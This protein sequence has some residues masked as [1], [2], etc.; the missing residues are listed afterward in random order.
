MGA[1]ARGTPRRF[2]PAVA[3]FVLAAV[4]FGAAASLLAAP[5]VPPPPPVIGGATGTPGRVVVLGIELVAFLL[6]AV[7]GWRIVAR[8]RDRVPYPS[9]AIAAVLLVFI[10]VIALEILLRFFGHGG[11]GFGTTPS[12]SPGNGTTPPSGGSGTN[13]TEGG[14]GAPIGW[15]GL[16]AWTE[17]VLLLVGGAV[18]AVLITPYLIAAHRERAT[19]APIRPGP[20]SARASIDAALHHLDADPDADPRERIIAAYAR[21]LE[22]IETGPLE[23]ATLTPREIERECTLRLGVAPPTAHELTLLFEEA[24]YSPHPIAVEAVGR[25]RAA[26]T[27]ALAD[28]GRRPLGTG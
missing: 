24:R 6:I 4:A 27:R 10:G 2:S 13:A 5:V 17:Y 15:T 25:A 23:L 3:V 21:L 22:R 28:L 12:P 16:P 20:P 11:G 1:T 9:T 8:L 18:T 7:V 19:R 14:L 26:L